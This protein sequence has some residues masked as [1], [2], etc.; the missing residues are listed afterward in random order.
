MIA[1]QERPS[2]SDAGKVKK[3]KYLTLPVPHY[4]NFT[5]SCWAS[6]QQPVGALGTTYFKANLSVPLQSLRVCI[7]APR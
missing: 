7:N 3:N 1:V 6:M 4:F 2:F 5:T